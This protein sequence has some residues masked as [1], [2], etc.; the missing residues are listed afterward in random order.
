MGHSS[1]T[2][3]AV[4]SVN[5][6]EIFCRSYI[7]E[8]YR[9]ISMKWHEFLFGESDQQGNHFA[10]MIDERLTETQQSLS[11]A[12][13][14]F[15]SRPLEETTPVKTSNKMIKK[16]DLDRLNIILR[17]RSQYDEFKSSV[18]RFSTGYSL[19]TDIDH[20]S[21][22]PTGGGKSLIF[23]LYAV[24]AKTRGLM[25]VVIVPTN[26]LKNQFIS[27]CRNFDLLGVDDFELI[28]KADI[29]FTTPEAINSRSMKRVL[30][31]CINAKKIERIF[32]DEAHM[33]VHDQNYRIDFENL[34]F[35]SLMNVRLTFLTGSLSV[36]SEKNTFKFV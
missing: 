14:E 17:K 24:E 32:V 35:L 7:L 27:N 25:T 23:F 4:Y 36:E 13:K 10:E 22:I 29:V 20:I 6:N 12:S 2:A 33:I 26:S 11:D 34:Q 19:F 16:N 8:E 30:C 15:Y 21:V 5:N 28:N 9:F 1:A 18:Q 31:N 3:N